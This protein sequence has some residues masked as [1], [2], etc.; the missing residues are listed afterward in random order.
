VVKLTIRGEQVKSLLE[1]G[2]A[3]QEIA[4]KLGAEAATVRTHT[5]A[6]GLSKDP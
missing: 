1:T 3:E 6:S 2:A 5:E 4:R